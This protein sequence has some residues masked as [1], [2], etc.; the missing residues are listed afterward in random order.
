MGIYFSTMP[1]I[2]P[3]IFSKRAMISIFDGC[4]GLFVDGEFSSSTPHKC[5]CTEILFVV[6]AACFEV[7]TRVTYDWCSGTFFEG[8]QRCVW[9]LSAW[10]RYW[11][12]SNRTCNGLTG[13]PLFDEETCGHIFALQCCF[14]HLSS[15][16]KLGN[17]AYFICHR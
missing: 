8:L 4:F 5:F 17:T 11:V 14:V 15:V 1:K 7:A 13:L 16:G 2:S 6:L 3:K 10:N 9:R 12:G